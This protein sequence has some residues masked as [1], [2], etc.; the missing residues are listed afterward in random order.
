MKYLKF[1]FVDAV[2]GISV[3]AEP[4]L[5]AMQ[6]PAVAGLEY[7]WARE[8]AYPTAVPELFGT[9]PDV[10]D[11]QIDGVLG[12]YCE[13]DFLQMHLDELALRDP[14]PKVVTMRQARL[15]LLGAGL[16]TTADQAIAAMTGAEGDAAR[17]EWEYSMDVRRDSGLVGS[18]ITALALTGE[19]V[20]ALF[21]IAAGL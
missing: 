5:H 11:T 18:M 21:V 3:A 15:A 16:L 7:V 13:P 9:C 20:D 6:F 1:T 2:T 10:S 8:S 4:V 12:L 14:A 17:I 19:Q